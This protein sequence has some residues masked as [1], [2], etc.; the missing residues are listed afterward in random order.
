ME[1]LHQTAGKASF[2]MVA[3]V[4]TVWACLNSGNTLVDAMVVQM[5]HR[6]RE[7]YGKQRLWGSVAMGVRHSKF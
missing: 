2:T 4:R 3:L 5:A 7:G 1:V 6:S